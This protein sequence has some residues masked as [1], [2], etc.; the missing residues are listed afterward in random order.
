MRFWSFAAAAVAIAIAGPVLATDEASVI[1]YLKGQIDLGAERTKV[2]IGFA[3]LNG[4][5]KDEAVA[6]ITGPFLCG[7][8][9][10][11]AHVLTPDGDSWREVG[12]TTVSSL[13]IGV[14]DSE[15]NGWKDLAVSFA[16]AAE[17]GIGQM[18]FESGSYDRNPTSAPPAENIGTLIIAE[19]AAPSAL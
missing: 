2:Y 12:N 4:D 3:D 16:S 13:P 1:D 19:D 10:C 15:T 14:L 5:D 7:S 17:S 9:G 11:N 18:K 6:F 8:G